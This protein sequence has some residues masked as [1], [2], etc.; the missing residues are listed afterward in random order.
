MSKVAT[1]AYN[2]NNQKWEA[3]Y[4]GVVFLSSQNKDYV[5]EKIVK[6]ISNK[7]RVLGITNYQ[8]VGVNTTASLASNTHA[9]LQAAVPQVYF[10]IDERFE[11]LE[12]FTGMVANRVIPSTIIVGEGGLGKTFTVMK[13]LA[14]LGF[15]KYEKKAIGA[16]EGEDDDEDDDAQQMLVP[17]KEN[18]FVVVKGYS[19]AR[20]LYR[21]LYEN[22]NS[23]IVFDDCDS[24]LRDDVACNLLKAALDSYDQR[25]VSWNSE[26]MN[27]DLPRSF[28][29]KGGVIF[30]SNLPMARIPQAVV[31]RAMVADVSMT[32]KEIV[33][34]M[35]TIISQNEFMSD[36]EKEIKQEALDFI[37]QHAEHP[38]VNTLNLRTLIG[39][40]KARQAN[41]I[42]WER[43][44]LYSMVNAR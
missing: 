41:P 13:T 8:E 9:S 20:G 11:F 26:N 18:E 29:F 25:I 44:A 14:K 23:I 6:Q 22:R 15:T 28:E 3:S 37:E 10:D 38:S 19:T 32:R 40:V 7:A 24:I 4:N 34:R 43:L 42:R 17:P 27:T 2:P 5:T 1:L 30:I 16:P 31:S 12:T 39:V 35:R 36:I 21:T 33:Q